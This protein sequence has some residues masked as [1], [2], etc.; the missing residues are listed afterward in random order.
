MCI[1]SISTCRG[2]ELPDKKSNKTNQNR[3]KPRNIARIE[4]ND[5]LP[6][7]NLPKKTVVGNAMIESA[8]I[9]Q[10]A[11]APVRISMLTIFTP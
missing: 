6:G 11:L 7:R 5:P 2:T 10:A 8:G 3:M 1:Q 9:N 4:I